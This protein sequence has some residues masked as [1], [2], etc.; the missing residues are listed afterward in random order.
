MGARLHMLTEC[1]HGAHN[2]ANTGTH[3]CACTCVQLHRPMS[4][5]DFTHARVGLCPHEPL[6]R[7]RLS[8]GWKMN[9]RYYPYLTL[10]TRPSSTSCPSCSGNPGA[11]LGGELGRAHWR[12]KALWEEMS[13][14]LR[15]AALPHH[16]HHQAYSH[17]NS[18][19]G[20]QRTTQDRR[21]GKEN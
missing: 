4:P 7:F 21:A 14:G 6:A 8:E 10:P 16:A 5:P 2:L 3:A 17:Q 20:G 9:L 19:M 11:E 1:L 13:F 15:E 18:Q 12:S